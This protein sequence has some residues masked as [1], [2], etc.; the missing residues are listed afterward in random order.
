[1][2]GLVSVHVV[3]PTLS[4]FPLFII[5]SHHHRISIGSSIKS[6]CFTTASPYKIFGNHTNQNPTYSKDNTTTLNFSSTGSNPTIQTLLTTTINFDPTELFFSTPPT[7]PQTF[8]DTLDDLPPTTTNPPPPRPSFDS[9][10]RLANE[11]T[12]IPAMEPPLP[13]NPTMKPSLPPLPP[14]I[15]TSPKSSFKLLATSAIRT[16]QSFPFANP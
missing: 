15:L 16:K 7:S 8:F 6:K 11:P 3:S 4:H 5:L 14:Q 12:P 9:I 1:M 2:L 10:E 13:P